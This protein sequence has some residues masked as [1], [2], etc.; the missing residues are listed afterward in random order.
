MLKK[1]TLMKIFVCIK[2]VPDT[3]TKVRPT[4]DKSFIET[5]SIKWI[6]SPYDSFAVE[7]ALLVKEKLDAATVTVVRVGSTKDTEALRIAMAMG[8][9]RWDTRRCTRSPRRL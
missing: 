4:A 1:D 5:D 3:E 7:Q 9:R 8:G 6:M 2:Q